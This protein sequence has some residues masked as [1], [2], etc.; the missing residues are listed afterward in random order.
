MHN[1]L[2]YATQ[3]ILEQLRVYSRHPIHI[4]DIHI[5]MVNDVNK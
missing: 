4:R 3:H 1:K 5:T 2:I